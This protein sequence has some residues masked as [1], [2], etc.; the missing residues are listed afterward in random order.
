MRA[1]PGNRTRILILTGVAA[2]LPAQLTTHWYAIWDLFHYNLLTRFG[3]FYDLFFNGLWLI[4]CSILLLN[5]SNNFIS[6]KIINFILLFYTFNYDVDMSIR[7]NWFYVKF[8]W[9]KVIWNFVNV[10]WLWLSH[11]VIEWKKN[12]FM[13]KLTEKGGGDIGLCDESRIY[14]CFIEI[15]V[16]N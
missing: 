13:Q 11:I 2:H 3:E 12:Y 7:I 8:C 1:L 5:F 4:K 14:G 6:Y 15:W 10:I 9:L 16:F